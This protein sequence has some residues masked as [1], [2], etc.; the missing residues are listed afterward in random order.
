MNRLASYMEIESNLASCEKN[1]AISIAL[2]PVGCTE[3]HGPYLPIQ[4]DTIVAKEIAD[5]VCDDLPGKY[6][7]HVFPALS[8]SPTKSNLW[9]PGTISIREDTFRSVV[10][11]IAES[12]VQSGFR[13]VLFLSGH[14]PAHPSLVEVCF[15]EMHQQY[16]AL[17]KPN[18]LLLAYSLADMRYLLE[19]RV[20]QPCGKHADWCE[21]LLL[22]HCLGEAY[23]TG[24]K[25]DQLSKFQRDNDF[26]MPRSTILGMPV[27]MKSVQGTIGEP[28]P[29]NRKDIKTLADDS[30]KA[31][32]DHI[33]LRL[34]TD[35]EQVGLL[36]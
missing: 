35:I 31:T 36:P 14:G 11:D 17:P 13:V 29:F 30:W 27:S 32:V 8:Y 1:N 18:T 28:L 10:R 19:E 9:Y 5:S 16:S 15:N 25:M 22:Y 12:M 26:S 2:F 20:G 21:L 3:Q 24:L 34:A 7:G 23:F 6:Y 33:C 4:T